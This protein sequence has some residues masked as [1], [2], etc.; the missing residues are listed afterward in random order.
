V[1]CTSRGGAP[2]NEP[3]DPR[4]WLERRLNWIVGDAICIFGAWRRRPDDAFVQSPSPYLLKCGMDPTENRLQ[5]LERRVAA[6]E[7]KFKSATPPDSLSTM[8]NPEEHEA[9]RSLRLVK[10]EISGKRYDPA[11]PDAGTYEG[12]IWF[13]CQYVA[14]GLDKPARAMKGILTFADHF[15]EVK[16]MLNVTINEQLNPGHRLVQN[17]IGFTYNQ[18]MDSHQWMLVTKERDMKMKFRLSKIL[19]TDGTSEELV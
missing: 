6:L 3:S 5:E 18:F 8:S 9:E 17:G 13:D 11:N 15:D 12:H 7:L 1:R 2:S 14:A 10:V 19:Y 16:F 4:L